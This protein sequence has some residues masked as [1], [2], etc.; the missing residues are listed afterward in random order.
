MM[1][2]T[3][4]CGLGAKKLFTWLSAGS[5]RYTTPAIMKTNR[6][7]EMARRPSAL[8]FFSDMDCTNERQIVLGCSPSDPSGG[9]LPGPEYE[10]GKQ[11][12]LPRPVGH[13]TLS[14]RQFFAASQKPVCQL[15]FEDGV[16]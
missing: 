3:T 5:Q 2:S 12:A 9:E 1:L 11:F 6:A 8:A 7:I 16:Q 14:Q 4:R 10:G 15:T 13:A